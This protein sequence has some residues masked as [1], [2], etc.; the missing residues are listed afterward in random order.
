[1]K[2]LT[3]KTWKASNCMFLLLSLSMVI[4]SFRF[5]G[6]EMYRVIVVKLWRSSNSSPN[7]CGVCVYVR[8]FVC[9][10]VFVC[11]CECLCVHVCLYVCVNVCVCVCAI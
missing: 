1:M 11:V 6:F 9:A 10:C 3:L 2:G 7:S 5:S 4:I 8:V